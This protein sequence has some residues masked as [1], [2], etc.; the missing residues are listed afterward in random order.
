MNPFEEIEKGFQQLADAGVPSSPQHILVSSW[1]VELAAEAGMTPQE[2]YDE[3][4][5]KALED[6]A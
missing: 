4:F 2:Y 6:L 5:E 1:F 3:V